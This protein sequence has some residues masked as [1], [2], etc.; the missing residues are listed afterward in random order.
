MKKSVLS[1]VAMMA[2]MITGSTAFAEGGTSITTLC[3]NGPA[4][5]RY[6]L[7]R[8]EIG[9]IS[10]RHSYTMGE[11]AQ[12]DLERQLE[13]V[14][15]PICLSADSTTVHVINVGYGPGLAFDNYEGV[16]AFVEFIESET[17]A[18]V[19]RVEDAYGINTN[20]S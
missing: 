16:I 9:S 8:D 11:G 6:D 4:M 3:N 5:Y 19:K 18:E 2:M 1:I 10:F 15:S 12:V 13:T 14:G 20:G 7:P 17:I